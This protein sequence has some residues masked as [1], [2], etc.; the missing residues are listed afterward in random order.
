MKLHVNGQQ[1]ILSAD[2]KLVTKLIQGPKKLIEILKKNY[3]P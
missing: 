2:I 3:N 1:L